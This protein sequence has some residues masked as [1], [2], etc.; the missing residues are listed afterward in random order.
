M[1]ISKIVHPFS[2]TEIGLNTELPQHL[3]LD[4]LTRNDF[5][6]LGGDIVA[7]G[8]ACTNVISIE[9]KGKSAYP[10]SFDLLNTA[11]TYW[12]L[13]QLK[14]KSHLLIDGENVT[15]GSAQYFGRHAIGNESSCIIES[16]DTWSILLGLP[17]LDRSEYQEEWPIGLE[18]LDSGMLPSKDVR[19]QP[20]APQYIQLLKG[21][22]E[23]D[24]GRYSFPI[25]L[26]NHIVALVDYY[27]LD[28]ENKTH[29]VGDDVDIALYYQAMQ[30][31]DQHF[32]ESDLSR[33]SI[34]KAL[35]VTVRKLN[36]AFEGKTQ[37]IIG[38]IN[39]A[40]MH[41]AKEL[42][43]N[44]DQSIEEIAYGVGFTSNSYMSRLYMQFFGHSPTEERRKSKKRD[45]EKI[46]QFSE[47]NH[48][49]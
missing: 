3:Y 27:H 9:I 21:F 16:G 42:L 45:F 43:R 48:S 8:R 46:L 2:R 39:I 31:I 22:A 49:E 36:R 38:V 25:R 11:N 47:N 33:E 13:V 15:V 10:I 6:P 37:N 34:A 17:N 40:R 19:I 44:T 30:Y 7:G 1:H 4:F 26:H 20:I 24:G 18:K 29:T 12:L 41:R 28:V 35:E 32:T 5:M 23:I 14:G